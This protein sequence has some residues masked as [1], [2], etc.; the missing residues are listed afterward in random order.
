MPLTKLQAMELLGVS[1]E[2]ALLFTWP[3]PA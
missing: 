2:W 3:P 1:I